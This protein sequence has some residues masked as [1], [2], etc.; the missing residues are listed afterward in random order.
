MA[1]AGLGAL[2][3]M[4]TKRVGHAAALA[5]PSVARQAAEGDRLRLSGRLATRGSLAASPSPT[6]PKAKAVRDPRAFAPYLQDQRDLEAT[7]NACG[8]TSAAMLLSFLAGKPGSSTIAQLDAKHRAFN[9]PSSPHN[10]AE[11]LAAGGKNHVSVKQNSNL[12]ELGRFVDQG[13]PA[14][15]LIDPDGK[16]DDSTLHYVLVTGVVR[17]A[18]GQIAKLH[19]ADPSGDAAKGP[20][21]RRQLKTMAAADFDAK[22]SNLKLLNQDAQLNRVIIA[23]TPKEGGVRFR[24]ADGQ[25]RAAEKLW[26][27]QNESLGF[28]PKLIDLGLDVGN[29]ADATTTWVGE[30]AGKL[31]DW[32]RSVWPFG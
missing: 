7:R 32:G 20:N 29:T 30:S 12:E 15:V 16:G 17:D 2:A 19:I 27:P 9:G 25:V 18:Q 23:A 26:R 13:T 6:D 14:L 31:G 8:T 4:N 22:W 5:G 21:P 1:I 24:G 10:L 3:P 28:L 11:A